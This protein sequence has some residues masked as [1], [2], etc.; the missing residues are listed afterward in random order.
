MHGRRQVGQHLAD[1]HASAPSAL[2]R[3]L[4]SLAR[5]TSLSSVRALRNRLAIFC[6]RLRLR[7][8]NRSRLCRLSLEGGP[9]PRVR[10]DRRGA[11]LAGARFGD[12]RA[13]ARES[14]RA[15]RGKKE[16]HYSDAV[17]KGISTAT[18]AGH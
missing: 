9:L 2:A 13:V 3:A 16:D 18:E 11:R 12:K 8:A 14:G 17:A 4:A 10:L 15:N 1:R 6:N 7:N 5:V